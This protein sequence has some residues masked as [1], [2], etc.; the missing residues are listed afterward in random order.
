MR[1]SGNFWNW[2]W[3]RKVWANPSVDGSKGRLSVLLSGKRVMPNRSASTELLLRTSVAF[4]AMIFGR[5]TSR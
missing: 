5:R 3:F 1:T 4:S 2:I